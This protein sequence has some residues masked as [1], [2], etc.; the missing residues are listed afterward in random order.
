MKRFLFIIISVFLFFCFSKVVLAESTKYELPDIKMSVYIPDSLYVFTRD[1]LDNNPIL[2]S[3]NADKETI[4]NEMLNFDIYLDATTPDGMTEVFIKVS[5]SDGSKDYNNFNFI[6]EDIL[7]TYSSTYTSGFGAEEYFKHKTAQALFI[8]FNYELYNTTLEENTWNSQY[9]TMINKQ[10]VIVV[11]RSLTGNITSEQENM[12]SEIVDNIS[13][14]EILE[15][16]E[17]D[18]NKGSGIYFIILI[19][20]LGIATIIFETIKKGKIKMKEQKEKKKINKIWIGSF[21]ILLQLFVDYSSYQRGDF[22]YAS[23]PEFI[24]SQFI[25]LFGLAFIIDELV[26]QRKT[27]K[28]LGKIPEKSIRH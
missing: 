14:Y 10:E 7:N 19:I 28:M 6:S 5:E 4:L 24:G 2:D 22:N 23:I 9:F 26:K 11:L 17:L 1:N 12:L 15:N 25:F 8:H 20:V 13:F 18:N 21:L 27:K 16:E 3:Y